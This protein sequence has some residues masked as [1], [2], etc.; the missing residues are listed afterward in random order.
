[1]WQRGNDNIICQELLLE[2]YNIIEVHIIEDKPKNYI[3]MDPKSISGD[4]SSEGMWKFSG[5]KKKKNKTKK[6]TLPMSEKCAVTVLFPPI[7]LL[8][9]SEVIL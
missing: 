7:T 8:P 6:K 9:S 4:C 3:S 2:T 1:M 5:P